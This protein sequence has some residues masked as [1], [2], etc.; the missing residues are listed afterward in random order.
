MAWDIALESL[1]PLTV[2]VEKVLPGQYDGYGNPKLSGVVKT[3]KARQQLRDQRLGGIGVEE[4]TSTMQL[5][6]NCQDVLTADDQITIPGID[7]RGKK[8]LRI[9][10]VDDEEG[11]HHTVVYF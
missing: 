11:P 4:V 7:L 5:Y 10:L 2:T 8:I 3:Y 9:R 6:L 1:M